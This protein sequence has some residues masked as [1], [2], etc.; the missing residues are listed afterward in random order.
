MANTFKN[1]GVVAGT[2]ATTLYTVPASTTAVIHAIHACNISS[3]QRTIT[4]QW[5]DNSA[6][7]T[8][9]L[10]YQAPIPV[11]S[12]LVFDKPVNLETG[13]VLEVIADAAASVEMTAAILEIS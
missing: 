8:Y 11:G 10:A 5:T 4:I 7:T 2:T 9:R 12:T 1:K 6:S 3:A 13:D